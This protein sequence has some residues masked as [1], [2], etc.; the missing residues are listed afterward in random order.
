METPAL[1][2]VDDDPLAL[3]ALKRVFRNTPYEIETVPSGREAL[4][5]LSSRKFSVLITDYQMPGM[6]GLELLREAKKTWPGVHRV[7][8][9]GFAPAVKLLAA[10]HEGEVQRFIPKPWDGD[11]LQ[12]AVREIL[13]AKS[14]RERKDYL[15]AFLKTIPAP[16]LIINRE[17]RVTLANGPCGALFGEDAQS[18][19]GKPVKLIAGGGQEEVAALLQ[20]VLREDTLWGHES[21]VNTRHGLVPVLVSVSVFRDLEGVVQG[22]IVTLQDINQQ[23]QAE[24]DLRNA[25]GRLGSAKAEIQRSAAE[26]S[27]LHDLSVRLARVT[28]I[29]QL[30][31]LATPAVLAE[32]RAH[33]AA[34]AISHAGCL[35]ATMFGAKSL[36][37]SHI[38][39]MR[40]KLVTLGEAQLGGDAKDLA[41]V[42]IGREDGPPL[43]DDDPEAHAASDLMI[44]L[45]VPHGCGG[46]LWIR[47]Y[48]KVPF[49][50]VEEDF[51]RTIALEVAL[52][53]SRLL[54]MLAGERQRM[55][56][57]AEG[58][59]EPMMM[60]NHTFD[61]LCVNRPARALL[62][63][64]ET[65]EQFNPSALQPAALGRLFERARLAP[66]ET[67]AEEILL[68]Q[69]VPR[70]Y[71]VVITPVLHGKT[72]RMGTVAVFH[73]VTE[74]REAERTKAEF[75]A[76]VS[77]EL[78]TPLTSIKESTSLLL[79]GVLGELSDRQREFLDVTANECA[80]LSRLVDD[81]LEVSR[82]EGARLHLN[83]TEASLGEVAESALTTLHVNAAS[84]EVSFSL[85]TPPDLPPLLID[86]DRVTQI[87]LN[88]LGNAIK[89]T[90]PGGSVR[91]EIENHEK[92]AVVR[93]IDSGIGIPLSESER[94]FEKFQ[95]V[96]SGRRHVAKGTGLGLFICKAL[97]EMHGG[98]ISLKSTPGKG[99][100][101]CFTLP[102]IDEM[103]A[104][105]DYLTSLVAEAKREERNLGVLVLRPRADR[106]AAA[107]PAFRETLLETVRKAIY[108]A[109]DRVFHLN[110]AAV[111]IVLADADAGGL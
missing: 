35:R 107:E 59:P 70:S 87:L 12:G 98:E 65:V 82:I 91:V 37:D 46:F 56:A 79:D 16:V 2:L 49:T 60:F 45:E 100:E 48:G 102:K 111:A 4:A 19:I 42:P 93:V 99:S 17:G 109:G 86:V 97:V 85:T 29:A 1:L 14:A 92:A 69:P 18:L 39:Q 47:R 64:S 71:R 36:E 101:F 103:S 88:L 21:T 50:P 34:F 11:E 7:I 25:L 105:A 58:M 24:R 22:T 63:I 76:N 72:Q 94:V 20:R 28:D 90:P 3:S 15:E 104:L 44:P 73:D 10:S 23:K 96:S 30:L 106:A 40:A 38:D 32:S 8:M 55:G 80:R 27:S 33:C 81:I 5:R 110:H 51:C 9:S 53:L 67:L 89:F 95:R 26:I 68:A 74:W 66:D 83:R 62:N 108:K 61:P 41:S 13:E 78:R 43:P 52:I 57:L 6:T 77:H 75:V 84:A 31:E 54:E